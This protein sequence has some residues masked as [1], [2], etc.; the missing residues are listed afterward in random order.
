LYS[1]GICVERKEFDSR[2]G[3]FSLLH[4]VQTRSEA[5]PASYAMGT[6]GS[7]PKGKADGEQADHSL[8]SSA[9]LKNGEAMPPLYHALMAYYFID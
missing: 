7:F 5:H 1:N 9:K 2:Q 6:G 8:P 3:Y 4:S